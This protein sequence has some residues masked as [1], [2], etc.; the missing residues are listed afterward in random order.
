M[1]EEE[2]FDDAVARFHRE[3]EARMPWPMPPWP[4]PWGRPSPYVRFASGDY[5]RFEPDSRY[6]GDRSITAEGGSALPAPGALLSR[7]WE[8]RTTSMDDVVSL[9]LLREVWRGNYICGEGED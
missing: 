5:L 3:Y 6:C 9:V 4:D 7:Q 1:A 8:R 2:T